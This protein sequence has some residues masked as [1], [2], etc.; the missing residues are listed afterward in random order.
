[1]REG[2]GDAIQDLKQV[3]AQAMV[4]RTPNA[5]HTPPAASH[6]HVH[7]HVHTH[8]RMHVTDLVHDEVILAGRKGNK[9]VVS[10]DL[11]SPIDNHVHTC[12]ILWQDLRKRAFLDGSK[13]QRAVFAEGV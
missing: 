6:T 11:S 3:Q 2:G 9:G 12:W 13:S 1:M 8:A 4:C 7:T 5:K 10:R